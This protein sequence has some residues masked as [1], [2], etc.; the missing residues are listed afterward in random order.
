MDDVIE[1]ALPGVHEVSA[2]RTRVISMFADDSDTV[3]TGDCLRDRVTNADAVFGRLLAGHVVV[4]ELIDVKRD[5]LQ[6]GWMPLAV[7]PVSV[8]QTAHEDVCVRVRRV[9]VKNAG[10]TRSRTRGRGSGLC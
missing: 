9:H 1:V 3:H 4:G 8:Q 2:R 6:S 5:W 10:D 7:K